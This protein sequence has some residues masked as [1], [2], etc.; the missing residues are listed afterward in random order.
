MVIQEAFNIPADIATGLA[1]GLYRRIGGVIRYARGP[2]KGK[3]VS[4]L[5]PVVMPKADNTVSVLSKSANNLKKNKKVMIISGATVLVFA[6]G[7]ALY[8]EIK[9]HESSVI[10]DF[11]KAL[12]EYVEAIRN[13]NMNSEIIDTLMFS[14][15]NMR[16]HKKYDSLSVK[17]ST[18][19]I[20]ILVDRIYEYTIKLADD[21]NFVWE[22]DN[23]NSKD[24][25]IINLEKY[26][27]VQKEIFYSAA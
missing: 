17:L 9:N 23:V 19:D 26:L 4:F 3:I 20:Y 11:R 10:T 21:N 27:T 8:Y 6:G 18:E 5:K 13:G 7:I 1:T 16:Q 12:A 14:L 24:K 22:K 15:E 2:Q 25:A